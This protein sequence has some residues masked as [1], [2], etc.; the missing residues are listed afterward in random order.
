MQELIK[1]AKLIVMVSHS[2]EF[3]RETATKALVLHNGCLDFFGD[4]D[5]GISRYESHCGRTS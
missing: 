2:S 5:E 3:V 4:V 1:S